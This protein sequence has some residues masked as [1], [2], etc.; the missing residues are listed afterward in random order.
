M[1]WR[2]EFF[3]TSWDSIDES[4]KFLYEKL[5]EYE[6]IIKKNLKDKEVFKGRKRK[7]YFKTSL[8]SNY[9]IQLD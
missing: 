8:D 6:N 9:N 7:N 2:E 5:D 3:E 4:W 1:N